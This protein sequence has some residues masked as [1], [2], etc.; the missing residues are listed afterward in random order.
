MGMQHGPLY[1]KTR[2]GQGASP[3]HEG[4]PLVW[5]PPRVH[6]RPHPPVGRP[7]VQDWTGIKHDFAKQYF[8]NIDQ[9]MVPQVHMDGSVHGQA[10]QASASAALPKRLR[11]SGV[12][13]LDGGLE[14][15]CDRSLKSVLLSK[16]VFYPAPAGSDARRRPRTNG[17]SWEW[18]WA[19]R[20]SGLEGPL[21][22]S[23]PCPLVH[24]R[25]RAS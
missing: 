8:P 17:Q 24:G 11:S 19:L 22:P 13:C 10:A 2:A 9:R 23:Q 14:L 15:S 21:V 12:G 1:M 18:L 6:S 20:A 16:V 25:R 3:L 4:R 5:L 7:S